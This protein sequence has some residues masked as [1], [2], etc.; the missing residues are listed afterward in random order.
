MA[1]STELS[2]EILPSDPLL[3]I[4]SF[5]DFKDL[6]SCSYVSRRLQELSNHNPLWKRH[7]QKY[8]L[9][10]E[11]DKAQRNQSW[12]DLFRE[13]YSD[14]GRYIEHYATLKR[15]WD[16]LKRY[17]DQECPR[18]IVSLK[19][20][21]KEDELNAIEAQIGCKLPHDYRCSFR[22]HN[23]QKLVVPGYGYVQSLD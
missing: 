2:L 19:D 15:A 23:G 14:L 21:V 1:T 22:I 18:M 11:S 13:F 16:D 17:L 6:I 8:W 3:L 20:G 5:L 7:C 12:K 4:L 10:S 9:L